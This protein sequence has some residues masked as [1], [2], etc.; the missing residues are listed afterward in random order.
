MT[1]ASMTGFARAEGE[2]SG[3]S[4]VWEA[5]SVN[6]RGLDI[7]CRLPSG[8][9]RLD[10]VLRAEAAKHLRRGNVSVTLALARAAGAAPFTVDRP[11]LDRV[12]ALQA[13]L[14]GRVDQAPPRIEALLQIPGVLDRGG[15]AEAVDEKAEKVLLK[16]FSQALKRLIA[17]RADEGARLQTVLLG[18]IDEIER[19]SG[20]AA[21]SAALRPDAV[22]ERLRQQIQTLLD[23]VPALPE[24]RLAQELALLAAKG[25]VR[26]ELDRLGA[27]VGQARDMLKEGGAI[28]RRLDF[29]SQEFNR[30]SNTLCSKSQDVALTRIGIALKS[31]IDQFR[32]QI[33][34]VE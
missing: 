14:L 15:L 33:Q 26:E 23:A 18:Q 6:G 25:D 30:E 1:I 24:E 20:E 12:L 10:P 9:D 21:A 29:L 17:A 27:H 16:G 13:D 32:E 28:G 22:K 34:N 31:V 19:L 2:T 4:W 3:L 11:V 5:R 7:R 8:L